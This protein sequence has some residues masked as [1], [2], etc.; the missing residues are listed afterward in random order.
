MEYVNIGKGDGEIILTDG[1]DRASFEFIDMYVVDNEEY[2]VLLQ[3]G[4]DMITIMRFS[5]SKGSEPEKFYTVEDDEVFNRV[6][7]MYEN[8][9]E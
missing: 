1:K 8:D 5:E 4:D 3:D 2:A 7:A 9:E 6:L